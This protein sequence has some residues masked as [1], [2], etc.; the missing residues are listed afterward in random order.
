LLW[1]AALGA[2]VLSHEH[3]VDVI[4]RWREVRVRPATRSRCTRP[5]GRG[6]LKLV[7]DSPVGMGDVVL[8]QEC[9]PLSGRVQVQGAV[10]AGVACAPLSHHQGDAFVEGDDR[11]VAQ[12]AF[13]C[14]RIEM[15]RVGQVGA[16]HLVVGS[17]IHIL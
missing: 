3:L 16:W 2:I 13:V 9:D 14:G 10:A 11:F 7:R 6:G 5:E 1:Q 8:V 15:K 4:P 17:L 12:A